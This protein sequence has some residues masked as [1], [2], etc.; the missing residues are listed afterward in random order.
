MSFAWFLPGPWSTP[1]NVGTGVNTPGVEQRATLSQDGERLYFGRD[2]DIFV[3]Q[4]G[5]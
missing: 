4:R 5:R 3:S 2:G 1:V